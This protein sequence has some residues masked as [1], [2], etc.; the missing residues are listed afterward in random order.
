MVCEERFEKIIEIC[1]YFNCSHYVNSIGGKNLYQKCKFSEHNVKIDFID[2]KV[3]DRLSIIHELMVFD[4][5]ELTKRV[6]N[7]YGVL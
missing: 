7:E 2:C 3:T 4:I 1:R 5:D 6:L